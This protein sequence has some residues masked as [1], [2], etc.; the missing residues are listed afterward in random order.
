M[1]NSTYDR[2]TKVN[3]NVDQHQQTTNVYQN[4]SDYQAVSYQ[5]YF[6]SNGNSYGFLQNNT[7][8]NNLYTNYYQYYQNSYPYYQNQ[9]VYD[10]STLN[11]QRYLLLN[12]SYLKT[13]HLTF[14]FI[15]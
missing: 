12:F 14:A 8:Y 9:N 5:N 10:A 3:E 1:Y 13:R 7:A 11:A 2:V 6:L 15:F 4:P